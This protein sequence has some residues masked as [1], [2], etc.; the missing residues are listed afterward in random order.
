MEEIILQDR[1]LF[2]YLNNLGSKEFDAF[3]VFVSGKWSWLPLYVVFLYLLYKNFKFK[4]VLYILFF[5]TLGIVV[6]DQLAG[7]FKYGILRL[8]P[9]HDP[10]LDSLMRE[11]ECGEQY[12][13]YS[14][15]A[16]NTFLLANFLSVLLW[17]KYK[18]LPVFLFAWSGLVA[19]SRIYLGVHFPLDIF[20]GAAMG[21]FI[22]GFFASLSQKVINSRSRVLKN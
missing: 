16:S 18:Y 20:M 14:S 21:Y 13:F 3:W 19:Y 15:H 17:R 10:S 4:N 22:G 9:C 12:G 7:I 8:R 5:L 6:S 2:L 1:E 11:V